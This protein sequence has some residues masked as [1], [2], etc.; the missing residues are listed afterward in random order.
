MRHAALPPLL[1]SAAMRHTPRLPMLYAHATMILQVICCARYAAVDD[2][3]V[4]LRDVV[5]RVV[6]PYAVDKAQKAGYAMRAAA[7][8]AVVAAA[9]R[10]A[11][12]AIVLRVKIVTV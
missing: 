12:R 1:L 5:M 4:T 7:A 3:D 11:A 9:A 10:A 6:T 2:Y 8:D